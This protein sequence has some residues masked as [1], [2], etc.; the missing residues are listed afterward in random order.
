MADIYEDLKDR[1]EEVKNETRPQKN[2]AQ[3]IGKLFFDIVEWVKGINNEL[4][5]E[6]KNFIP[7]SGTESNR[8]VTGNIA[9][10]NGKGFVSS[11]GKSIG[12]D[13]NGNPT[14]ATVS[15]FNQLKSK[16]DNHI[17]NNSVHFINLDGNPDYDN[18]A[19]GAYLF[20]E[21]SGSG[22]SFT[23]IIIFLFQFSDKH[24]TGVGDLT[25]QIRFR[26]GTIEYRE[27]K[28]SIYGDW[29]PIQ[30]NTVL[31][32]HIENNNVHF[33]D[34]ELDPDI[35]NLNDDVYIYETSYGPTSL[36]AK[37]RN[38]L[39]QTHGGLAPYDFISQ[40]K[41]DPDGI[42]RRQKINSGVWSDWVPI[43]DGGSGIIDL[44]RNPDLD[45]LEDGDYKYSTTVSKPVYRENSYRLIQTHSSGG[46]V[47]TVKQLR[48]SDSI[49]VRTSYFNPYL[50]QTI[51]SDWE[52]ITDS[53]IVVDELGNSTTS[54]ISQA[55]TTHYINKLQSEIDDLQKIINNVSQQG[56]EDAP[57]D[58][59]VY[60]RYN[61][62]WVPIGYLCDYNNDYNDDYS[63]PDPENEYLFVN[64]NDVEIPGEIQIT[65]NKKWNIN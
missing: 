29:K 39:F 53:I 50:Q 43:T 57:A 9:V 28:K 16:T 27:K 5:N 15:D 3:R 63:S 7:L 41:I 20:Y 19:D 42:K 34:L 12:F 26:S 14:V 64:T 59:Y 6:L 33:V 36:H 13:A 58:N 4:K 56:I 1:T 49:D 37:Y 25:T 8:P 62:T 51:W 35:D 45:N 46:N 40:I 65:T 11:T 17:E 52:P 38:W 48:F 22:Q 44:G 61:N 2:A 32:N 55:I 30:D 24:S 10:S 60:A 47:T 31:N 23:H 54:A 18:L 21:S